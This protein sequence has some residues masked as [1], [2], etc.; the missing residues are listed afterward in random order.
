[1]AKSERMK[2]TIK[3]ATV[4]SYHYDDHAQLKR[5]LAECVAADNFDRRLKSLTPYKFICKRWTIKPERFRLDPLHHL[6]GR[7]RE[8][9]DGIWLV[10][11]MHYDPGYIDVEQRAL[12]TIDNPF[13]T[14]LSPMS[15]RQSVADLSGPDKSRIG[16][17]E[18]N[19]TLDNQLGK[20]MF[21]H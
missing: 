9:D 4:K 5:H 1:M 3:D 19:R 11:F 14:K 10:T 15:W 13:G 18:G 2:R 7:H 6:P 21:Y 12:Q 8:V 16:A 17:G 20:L